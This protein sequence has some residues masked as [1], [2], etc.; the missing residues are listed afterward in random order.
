MKITS[1]TVR[2][3][4]TGPGYNNVAHEVTA[5]VEDG[6]DPAAVR[7]ALD[8]QV[9]AWNEEK[10]VLHLEQQKAD[11]LWNIK[12]LKSEEVAL[13]MQIESIRKKAD[14][15]RKTP[16]EQLIANQNDEEKPF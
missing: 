2:R 8:I 5:T 13:R 4:K 3:L 6:E 14:E 9:Q 7:E 11:A 15:L 12:G 10:T 16:M 1:V